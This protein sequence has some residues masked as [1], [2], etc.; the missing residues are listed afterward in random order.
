MR[1]PSTKTDVTTAHSTT[2]GLIGKIGNL[3]IKTADCTATSPISLFT[4]AGDVQLKVIGIV[5]TSLT[6]SDAIAA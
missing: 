3:V 2:D 1:I 6:M 4:V 5:K